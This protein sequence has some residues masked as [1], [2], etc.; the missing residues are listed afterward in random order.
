MVDMEWQN[1]KLYRATV[2]STLGGNCR[3][4]TN[5]RINIKGA[6]P[7]TAEGNNPNPYFSVID[8]GQ[9][10]NPIHAE[11]KE[12]PTKSFYTEDFMTEKGGRYVI[13]VK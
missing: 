7:K 13:T 5:E 2:T 1:G 6:T 10:Q 11:L 4:K 8:P 12:I 9:A 3:L